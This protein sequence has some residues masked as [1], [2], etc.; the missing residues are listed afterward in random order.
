MGKDYYKILGV[1]KNASDDDIKKAYRKMA[2]KYH[3]DKNNSPGAEEKFKEVSEA[4]EVLCD[5]EKRS[6]F[7]QFG[8]EGLRRGA[9]GDDECHTFTFNGDPYKTFK[10]FFSNSSED[11]EADD[12]LSDIFGNYSNMFGHHSNMFGN[13]GN[14]FG[15]SMYQGGCQGPMN[16]DLF[17]DMFG[18][19]PKKCRVQDPPVNIELPVTLEEVL[20]GAIKKRKITKRV[21]SNDTGKLK[22]DEKIVTIEVKKGWKAGTKVGVLM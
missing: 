1:Y 11:M 7:D 14:M 16:E 10:M 18:H 9:S 12:F 21:F 4:Y 19:R 5:R 13:H 22:T 15:G 3:P 6:I 20:K 8:E 17:G 2:L